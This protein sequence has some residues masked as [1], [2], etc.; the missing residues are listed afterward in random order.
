MSEIATVAQAIDDTTLRAQER[1]MAKPKRTPLKP[2]TVLSLVAF[3]VAGAIV[4][5]CVA[6][7]AR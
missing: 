7:A 6:A 5:A 3:A 4:L 2:Q 1:A